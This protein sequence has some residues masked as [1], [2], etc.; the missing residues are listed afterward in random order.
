LTLADRSVYCQSRQTD[1]SV[2]SGLR[3]AP[4]SIQ[5]TRS[6]RPARL[7]SGWLPAR[8]A[9][10]LQ[11]SI[12]VL[13]LAASSAPTPLY[14]SYQAKWGFSPITTTIVFG[15]Y[16]L[17]VLVALLT[18]GSLSDYIGRRPVLLGALALQAAA[19]LVFAWADGVTV[20]MVGRVV[21][22]VSTGAAAGAV[23]AGLLDLNKVK[24]TAANGVA[25]MIGTGSGA[26]ASGLLVQ[27]LPYPTHLIYL[28]LLAVVAVQ[29]IGVLLMAETASPK[30]GALASLRP[31]FT[32]P[33]VARRPLLL[34]APALVAVWSL[35][36]FYGSL[37]PS[38]VRH[39][40]H[41]DSHLLGGLGLFALAA[42]GAA[43]VLVVRTAGTRSVLMLGTVALLIGVGLTLLAIDDSS[44]AVF[45]LG[46]AIAGIGFGA[47]FQ[48]SVRTVLPLAEPH[49][50]AGVLSNVY[51]VCYLAMGLPA[52]VAGF[53]VVHGGGL[54]E[55]SKQYSGYVMVLAVLALVGLIL[56]K[57]D[58]AA[59][60][61][62]VNHSAGSAR[63]DADVLAE[64]AAR[65]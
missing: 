7:R 30:T 22:G 52:V 16:A 51:V 2:H 46:A 47:G 3:E 37:A 24:G 57:P 50:R 41:S 65:G 56:A 28:V 42:T 40:A 35:A 61:S 39:L 31:V 58:N 12:V 17:A 9:F 63:K 43:T 15:V 23:G 44:I 53:L 20:L 29:A 5:S 48:G 55:T 21:Q 14:S 8:V 36:G 54:I 10:Y 13:L 1:L 4:M 60:T 62:K 11:A 33:P 59:G 38:L 25:P 32:M 26:L 34:V 64:L 6:A 27:F 19:M 18:V 49:E 45:F